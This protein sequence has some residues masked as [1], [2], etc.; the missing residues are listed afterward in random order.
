MMSNQNKML[1]WYAVEDNR[2]LLI[3]CSSQEIMGSITKCNKIEYSACCETDLSI[4]KSFIDLYSAQTWLYQEVQDI[5]SKTFCKESIS[6]KGLEM[7]FYDFMDDFNRLHKFLNHKFGEE[8][9]SFDKKE[10]VASPLSEEEVENLLD[11]MS[12]NPKHQKA[13]AD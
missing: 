9:T 12:F 11:A 13:Q 6:I 8:Y 4:S 2:W 10:S 5:I 3:N 1:C 7:L